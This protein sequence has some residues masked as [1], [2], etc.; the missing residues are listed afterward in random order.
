MLHG[1]GPAGHFGCYFTTNAAPCQVYVIFAHIHRPG[2]LLGRKEIPD[3]APNPPTMA[4]PATGPTPAAGRAIVG[5][6]TARP[7]AGPIASP[8]RRHPRR[9]RVL[10]DHQYRYLLRQADL[11]VVE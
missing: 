3:P 4:L 10:G 2:F 5:Q 6:G 8:G 9:S 1:K 11:L 7:T